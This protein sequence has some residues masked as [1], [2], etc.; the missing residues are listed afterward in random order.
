[1]KNICVGLLAHVDAGK[2][3]LTES[4]LY[5]AKIIR[6]MGRV[7]H[8]NA[9][10]DY[11]VQERERGITIYSKE[12]HFDY[13]D[14]H[15]CLIDTPGHVDFSSEMERCL[16]VLDYAILI[17]SATD[18]V[19]SH[20][21]TIFKLLDA[22]HIPFFIFVNKMDIS[23]DSKDIIL[24][25]LRKD[26]N[27][28]CVDILDEETISL[29]DEKMMNYYL[30]NNRLDKM[31]VA[32]LIKQRKIFPCIFGSALKNNNVD[33]LLTC[34]A[35][36]TIMDDYDDVF[37]ARVYKVSYENNTKLSH[38]KV[39]GGT[40]R[41]KMKINDD[42]VDQIRV[43][44]GNK[45]ELKDSVDAG[46]V[47]CVKGLN[48]AYS[49]MG[50]G[51]IDDHKL[52]LSSYLHYRL[53]IKDQDSFSVYRN[54]EKLKMED[55]NLNIN[56]DGKQINVSIM[57]EVQIE[58]LKKLIKERFG[59]DVEFSDAKINYME[60]ISAPIEGVG[61]Y[62]PLR[63][64]GEVHLLLEPIS[65]GVEICNGIDNTNDM[66]YQKVI[67]NFLESIELKGI[68]TN[69]PLTNIRITLLAFKSHLKHSEPADFLEC[70]KRAIRHA[71]KRADNILLEPYYHFEIII[72]NNYV[73][74][75]LYD[76]DNFNAEYEI[77]NIDN[78]LVK[79]IG[80]ASVAKMQNYNIK[81]LSLTSGMGK[82]SMNIDGYRPCLEQEK[83]IAD[84]AYDDESDTDNP[85]GS[86][87]CAH[88]AGFYVNYED[89]EHYMHIPY[90]Y[91]PKTAEQKAF[92][93]KM[94]ISDD[95][96]K[97]VW[98][99]TYKP[100]EISKAKNEKKEVKDYY[101]I[102]ET[103]PKCLLVDGYNVIFG[104]S[105]LKQMAAKSLDMARNRLID[106]MSEYQA[107]R[108][109]LVIVV[110]DAYKTEAVMENIIENKN[111]VIVYTK[112][113][114]TADTYIEKTVAKLTKDYVVSVATSDSLEQLT[115]MTQN[116]IR[117][118]SSE[119]EKDYRFMKK[120]IHDRL[121]KNRT[122]F[123]NHSLKDIIKYL[124]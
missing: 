80:S 82:I 2:T 78:E 52:Q 98:N 103:K 85:S 76:L 113:K 73:S 68:L 67:M 121:Q 119:L 59:Y 111:V 104:W 106:Y 75:V 30:D 99:N 79:I 15:F 105:D 8:Q 84:I 117:I 4:L 109:D 31:M 115:V 33:Q 20:T 83:V 27:E 44:N 35:D 54:L 55:P 40:L 16:S 69:S 112:N 92:H 42:K 124:E 37:R 1:M 120:M 32:S 102:K 29:Y 108:Y 48:S 14:T 9:Y 60:T 49:G 70:C 25:S 41:S 28:H 95:E 57:G 46:N 65:K 122:T 38:L 118:S 18:K 23:Y 58:V 66:H 34:L 39:L 71:L 26:L 62:E 45:Y 11:D 81:F 47:V 72:N 22:M 90:V 114:H 74:K 10:L 89:V 94:S 110:F 97:R 88:G 101:D 53:D 96:L 7:D 12:V 56:Y 123:Y 64:Y 86:I 3:S 93:N 5:N 63:H 17:I 77:S 50:L 116:A 87:F 43:Y 100:K 24:N 107:Y 6:K 51:D 21:K 36:Y 61:H 19:Q 91:L 13:Q